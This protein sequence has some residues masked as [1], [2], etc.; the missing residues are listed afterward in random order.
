MTI[1]NENTLI[2]KMHKIMNIWHEGT[3]PGNDG[4][5]GNTLEDLLDVPENNFSLPDFGSIEIKTQRYE[6]G[7]LL[8]LFH[9][10]PKPG[11]S[12]PKLLLSLGWRHN[13]A[14]KKYNQ[15]EMSFRSTTYGH[16][17]SDRGFRIN[18]D[19][20]KI[21][22]KFD[23]S[24]VNRKAIDRTNIYNNYGEWS[25]DVKN[26][27]NPNYQDV[28]PVYYLR[29]EI[30]N[31]FRIKLNHTLFVLCSTRKRSGIKQYCYK[32]A[33]LLKDIQPQK[34]SNLINI[35]RMV[36]D[37]DART[38]HN[39]G[40]KFRIQKNELNSLFDNAQQIN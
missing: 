23:P 2:S 33:F 17:F 5:A 18:I 15:N 20:E 16:R 1:R 24:K 37:F 4:N 40:T 11:G 29:S 31:Q 21:L 14:G 19:N 22:F 34:I 38:K 32:E 27:N 35:G 9:K 7:S 6:T 25:D 39:H 36:I 30:E 12:V 13:E 10:E 28:L 3:R 8:T 26:R